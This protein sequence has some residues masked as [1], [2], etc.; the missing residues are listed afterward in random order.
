MRRQ[1]SENGK[2]DYEKIFKADTKEAID[3]LCNVK[4]IGPKVASCVLL[5]AFE[6]YDAF[7]I[8]VWIK[9]VILKYFSQENEKFDPQTLGEYAGI[10]QQYLFYYERYLIN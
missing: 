1:K 5:F 2:I 9:K 3:I 6:K 10:A 4:G 8:D 7:P